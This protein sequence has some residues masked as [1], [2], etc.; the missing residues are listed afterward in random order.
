M[1]SKIIK[2]I[3]TKGIRGYEFSNEALKAIIESFKSRPLTWHFKSEKPIG[4]IDA[5]ELVDGEL[6]A[7]GVIFA[8]HAEI[9]EKIE[10]T[11]TES[12]IEYRVGLRSIETHQEGTT[13][14]IDKADLVEVSIV[15]VPV[16]KTN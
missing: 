16:E 15:L 1:D 14:V 10:K 4:R 13:K 5:V 2:T 9:L 12:S 11:E 3:I 8:K 6:V 7:T